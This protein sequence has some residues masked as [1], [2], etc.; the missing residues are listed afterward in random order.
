MT[1]EPIGDEEEKSG[2]RHFTR[3]LGLFDSSMIVIGIMV[4]SIVVVLFLYRPTTTWPG[5]A[6]VVAGVPI[7]LAM[8]WRNKMR[9][10]GLR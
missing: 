3:G 2:P 6:I 4:G 9:P 1:L 7:Y 8:R 5:L 10:G